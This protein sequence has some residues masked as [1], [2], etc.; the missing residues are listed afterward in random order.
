MLWKVERTHDQEQDRQDPLVL[1]KMEKQNK[2]HGN[3]SVISSF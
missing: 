1:L 2:L 3:E